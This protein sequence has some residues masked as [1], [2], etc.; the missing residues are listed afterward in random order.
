MQDKKIVD[1]VEAFYDDPS[2][3]EPEGVI[4]GENGKIWMEAKVL[5]GILIAG[6]PACVELTVKNHSAK[7]VLSFSRWNGH[8]DV[9]CRIEFRAQCHFSSGAIFAGGVAAAETTFADLGHA[10]FSVFS[11]SGI[12]HT[13][14]GR[15]RREP[16]GRRST[17]GKK[18]EG[19]S[20]RR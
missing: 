4:V 11:W 16:C 20:E 5:G 13:A 19:W 10:Y 7:K 15:R 9:A 1:V 6:Q 8:I 17:T 12:R 3:P 18:R 14:G 2:R